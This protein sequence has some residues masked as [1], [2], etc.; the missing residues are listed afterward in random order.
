MNYN[1]NNI[2]KIEHVFFTCLRIKGKKKKIGK[3]TFFLKMYLFVTFPS[4][5]SCILRLIRNLA[6]LIKS[7]VYVFDSSLFILTFYLKKRT[8]KDDL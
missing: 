6:A 2:L 7:S 5:F 4:H 1:S 3:V 8:Q